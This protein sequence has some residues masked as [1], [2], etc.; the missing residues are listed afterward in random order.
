MGASAFIT[1]SHTEAERAISTRE[2]EYQCS[3]V[4]G[5]VHS[6]GN[7]IFSPRDDV[8]Y[9]AIGNRVAFVDLSRNS[10]NAVGNLE[11][12][13]TID[14]LVLSSD[15]VLL[16]A[17]DVEGRLLA[18]NVPRRVVLHRLNLK[19]RCR[20]AAFSHDNG[21]LAVAR[22]R[23]VQLWLAPARR[24]RELAPFTKL[25]TFG[26]A[27]RDTTCIKWSRDSKLLAVGSEDATV[28]VY[29][30]P[31]YRQEDEE[32]GEPIKAYKLSAHK[33]SIVSAFWMSSFSGKEDVLLSCA[34][35][36]V[37]GVWR[38]CDVS[39]HE[40]RMQLATSRRELFKLEK[41][42]FLWSDADG[43]S[44][45]AAAD[46]K[47]S[48][49]VAAFASGVFAVYDCQEDGSSLE[50]VHRLSV[51]RGAVDAVALTNDGER[52]A[53]ASKRFGQL[54]VW[55]WRSETFVLKQQGHDHEAT[56]V[57]WSSDGRIFASGA[58]DNKVKL[59]SDQSG[60]CFATFDDHSAPITGLAFSEATNVVF[61]ASRD[62]TVR[63]Y[64]LTRY[65][66][67]R[68][69]AAPPP[70]AGA[71]SASL[72]CLAVDADGEIACAG[73]DDP[74][75]IYV[76]SVRTGKLLDAL[77]SHTGPLS[78]LAFNPADGFLASGGWDKTVRLWNVFRNEHVEKLDHPSE[79]LAVAYRRDGKQLCSA[80]MDGAIH[81][82]EAHDGRLVAVID[83]RR[84]LAFDDKGLGGTSA[85]PASLKDR[86]RY[87]DALS[88]SVD[89]R[90]LLA[91]GR[92][93]YVCV[94]AVR[95]K[96]LLK[97][98]RISSHRRDRRDNDAASDDD[99]DDEERERH[100]ASDD[101]DDDAALPGAKRMKTSGA[102]LARSTARVN[103]VAFS[104]TGRS[105]VVVAPG[106]LLTYS[107]Q[108]DATFAPFEIDEAVTPD[109]T[110]EALKSNDPSKAL[111]MAL[112]LADDDL[113]D[114]VVANIRR[115]QIDL[116]V[117]GV[118]PHRAPALLRL[119][120]KRL[121]DSRDLEFYIVWS[122][123][124]LKTHPEAL[125]DDAPALRTLQKTLFAHQRSLLSIVQDNDFALTYLASS[126]ANTSSRSNIS[127][128]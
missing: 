14:R 93:R 101:E 72:T 43:R 5:A 11:A 62:G 67:F 124:I 89:G 9:S 95:Q 88:Y 127:S 106:A 60:Y 50:C 92:S 110:R 10:S 66:N 35:D 98:F 47:G 51:A 13:N 2:M 37:V 38:L 100:T 34:A 108:D 22:K 113:L 73:S 25:Q 118:P 104:P 111:V 97:K 85:T 58:I 29:I 121:D 59:W 3:R 128:G 52:I 19:S 55:E 107:I 12:R 4:A 23:L 65:R 33:D 83:C 119:I 90:C 116:V 79:V 61:S 6:S 94:Y 115:D 63:A 117:K 78:C 122:L 96:V 91:G 102:K 82:W 123:K 84:D 49:L 71:A 31:F 39:E 80:S 28:R 17:I 99:D 112:Q 41:K 126:K 70:R 42:H 30:V 87:F 16:C 15:G 24:R 86:A 56:C 77:A 27:H 64:D 120:A 125:R 1:P 26:G 20:D 44:V 8:L 74:F 75:D 105:F 21:V 109:A 76:W 18:V 46:F 57:A 32:G 114:T 69:L 103:A 48:L 53:L 7:V 45:L 81:V 36:C 40:E 54:A 68:T